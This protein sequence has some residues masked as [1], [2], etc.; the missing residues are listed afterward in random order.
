MIQECIMYSRILTCIIVYIETCFSII[1]RF[2]ETRLIESTRPHHSRDIPPSSP[3][4]EHLSPRLCAAVMP[5]HARKWTR[6]SPFLRNTPWV[7]AYVFP[8]GIMEERRPLAVRRRC[9]KARGRT[10]ESE[11]KES[12]AAVRV[13][14]VGRRRL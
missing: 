6:Q 7:Q 4:W 13:S 3:G 1:R 8:G 12:A 11:E 10:N 14:D 2:K 9:S 5:A